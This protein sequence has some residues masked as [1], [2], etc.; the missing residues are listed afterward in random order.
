MK[1]RG[2]PVRGAITGFLFGVLVFIDLAIFK[3]AP[4]STLTMIG[5][6]AVGLVLGIA[7]GFTAPFGRRKATPA[8]PPPEPTPAPE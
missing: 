4:P 6:P 8:P 5:L 2:H 3:V 1:R 7:L